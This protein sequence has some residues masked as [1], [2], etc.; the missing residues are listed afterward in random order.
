MKPNPTNAE[1]AKQAM[2]ANQAAIA[3]EEKRRSMST[4]FDSIEL[5]QAQLIDRIDQGNWS[6][7]ENGSEKHQECLADDSIL[8]DLPE[9]TPHPTFE[10]GEQLGLEDADLIN[11]TSSA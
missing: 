9:E 3:N 5:D 7:E 6:W 1:V 11:T 2:R 8:P 4:S 10:G